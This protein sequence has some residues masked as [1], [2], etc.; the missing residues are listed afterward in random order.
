MQRALIVL[1]PIAAVALLTLAF[2]PS[3]G[4]Q[5]MHLT[6]SG[7]PALENGHYYEGW[8]IIDGEE[9]STGRFNVGPDGELVGL[10][11]EPAGRQAGRGHR[12]RDQ[13]RAL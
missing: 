1:A 10:D 12:R 11:G 3:G 4:K 6:F 2:W 8:A 9:W 7:L 13:P 5:N